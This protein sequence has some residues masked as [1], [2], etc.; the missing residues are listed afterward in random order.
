MAGNGDEGLEVG[1]RDQLNQ[2]QLEN[3]HLH[4]RKPAILDLDKV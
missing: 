2:V 3:S 1:D 4:I